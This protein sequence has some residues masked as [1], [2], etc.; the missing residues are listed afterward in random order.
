MVKNGPRQTP[1]SSWRRKTKEAQDRRERK[2]NLSEEEKENKVEYMTD[3]YLTHKK[4]IL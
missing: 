2:K 4:N 1:K 3:Y